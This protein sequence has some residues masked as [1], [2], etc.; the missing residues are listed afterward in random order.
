VIDAAF[1]VFLYIWVF[2]FHAQLSAFIRCFHFVTFFHL[3]SAFLYIPTSGFAMLRDPHRALDHFEL[4]LHFLVPISKLKT[5]RCIFLLLL[6]PKISPSTGPFFIPIHVQT[7]PPPFLGRF[8]DVLS[9][10]RP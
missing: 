4:V 1:W 7:Q 6:R 8:K 10:H 9:L 2:T 5:L 3:K